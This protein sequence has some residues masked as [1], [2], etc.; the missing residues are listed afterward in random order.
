MGICSGV[1]DVRKLSFIAFVREHNTVSK[2]ASM[3][4]NNKSNMKPTIINNGYNKTR[5][6]NRLNHSICE[7]KLCTKNVFYCL[8]KC[9]ILVLFNVC[10]RV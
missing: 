3:K 2:N 4:L 5:T 7:E 8:A 10:L 9:L 1:V 6:E